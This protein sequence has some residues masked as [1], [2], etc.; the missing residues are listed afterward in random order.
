MKDETLDLANMTVEDLFRSKAER[1]ERLTNLPFEE[2]IGIVK[3]IQSRS[4]FDRSI[5]ACVKEVLS[6]LGRP[7]PEAYVRIKSLPRGPG[8]ALGSW[9]S[10][11][12][13]EVTLSNG[14]VFSLPLTVEEM[15]DAG[16]AD[17]RKLKLAIIRCVDSLTEGECTNDTRKFA[18]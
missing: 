15:T 3:R 14:F 12:S 17:C 11:G 13:W 9:E 18:E 1:R 4:F 2:K 5:E 7:D 6:D 16:S 8:G 10:A